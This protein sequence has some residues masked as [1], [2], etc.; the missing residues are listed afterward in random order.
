MARP[1][2]GT[3]ILLQAASGRADTRERCFR[4]LWQEYYPRLAV[5][6][7][8]HGGAAD[9]ADDIAQ[10]VMEKVF[11][12]LPTYDPSWRFSTWVF[13]IARN[14]CRDRARRARTRPLAGSLSDLPASRQPSH[15]FTPEREL[16]GKETER[17]IEE[18]LAAE[19][20]DMRQIAFLRFHQRMRYGEIARVMDMPV[21]TVKFRIHDVRRR[22]RL[23]MEED[24]G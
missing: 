12:A 20:P 15:A 22:L 9:E 4:R 11:R 17:Q 24:N 14:A 3:A 13:T 18:F 7:R 23:H 21:G 5:F 19:E 10:E 2:E 16:L 6:V 1:L 8:A